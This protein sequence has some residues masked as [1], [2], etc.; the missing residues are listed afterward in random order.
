MLSERA[1]QNKIHL[2]PPYI[3]ESRYEQHAGY[4]K[5]IYQM[6]TTAAGILIDRVRGDD[7]PPSTWCSILLLP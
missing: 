4:S 1:A 7:G 3:Q 6:G 5:T 2:G